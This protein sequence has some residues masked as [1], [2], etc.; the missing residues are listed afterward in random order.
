MKK[1]IFLTL[2]GIA[3]SFYGYGQVQP[4]LISATVSFKTPSS[5]QDKDWNT[6]ISVKIFK[7]DG[8]E[9]AVLADNYNSCQSDTE[10]VNC[11]CC[12]AYTSD[13]NGN[14]IK[15]GTLFLANGSVRG[16]FNINITQ[17]AYKNEIANGYMEVM[18][19]PVGRDTWIFAASLTL[20]FDDGTI[21]TLNFNNMEVE[22]TAPV[23]NLILHKYW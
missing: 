13:H 16:P 21:K 2:V 19:M 20:K 7:P 9:V 23:A 8:T 6:K 22:Q 4:K 18:I 10:P 12:V 3:I 1:I 15:P 14:I 11:F 17:P 5:G